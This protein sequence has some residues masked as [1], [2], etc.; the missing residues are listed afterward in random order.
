MGRILPEDDLL[1]NACVMPC[2]GNGGL[3]HEYVRFSVAALPIPFS[4]AVV[5]SKS[6][7]LHAVCGPQISQEII[8][9]P[10][11]ITYL[12]LKQ[13]TLKWWALAQGMPFPENDGTGAVDVQVCAKTG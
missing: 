11:K 6:S 10:L 3:S 12:T 4:W 7:C 8:S 9:C 2:P 1:G 13:P 5:P